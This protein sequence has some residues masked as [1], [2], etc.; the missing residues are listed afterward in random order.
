MKL[1]LTKDELRA[2]VAE[3]PSGYAVKID[4]HRATLWG[5]GVAGCVAGVLA[6]GGD[7][8]H[9]SARAV[10]VWRDRTLAAVLAVLRVKATLPVD[11]IDNWTTYHRPTAEGAA[12]HERIKAGAREFLRCIEANAPAGADRD[13][14]YRKVREAMMTASAAI[15][16]DAAYQAD[17]G[18]G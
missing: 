5:D 12:R 10:E 15:A 17:G 13:A 1:K 7:Y 6:D 4:E 16:C 2:C 14:A 11:D 8:G 3:T 9:V 18:E